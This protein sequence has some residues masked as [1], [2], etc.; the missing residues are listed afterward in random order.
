MVTTIEE[1]KH[2]GFLASYKENGWLW[3][4]L[5]TAEHYCQGYPLAI[6]T[7][8]EVAVDTLEICPFNPGGP[9]F[10]Q[11]GWLPIEVLPDN[12]GVV[13]FMPELIPIAFEREY[14]GQHVPIY[15]ENKRTILI[16]LKNRVKKYGK[17]RRWPL[18][19]RLVKIS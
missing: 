15:D 4:S 9:Y 19:S 7:F 11:K 16:N 12:G 3:L 14:F 13:I 10:L 8:D 18:Y 5:L 6:A 17:P 2:K 1:A